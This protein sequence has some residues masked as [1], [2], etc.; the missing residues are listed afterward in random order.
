MSSLGSLLSVSAVL[1]FIYALYS[2]FV[3]NTIATNFVSLPVFTSNQLVIKAP[4]QTGSSIEQ[5]LTS[6]IEY[7]AF[8]NTPI[9]AI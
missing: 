8:Q 2:A 5:A 6:P 1:V 7:H 4:A 3:S 9:I